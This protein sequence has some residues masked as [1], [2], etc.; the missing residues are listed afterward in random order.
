[1]RHLMLS[2]AALLAMAPFAMAAPHALAPVQHEAVTLS[3]P[4][5]PLSNV[6]L[7]KVAG[8]DLGLSFQVSA[9]LVN[10]GINSSGN[11]LNNLQSLQSEG[12]GVIGAVSPFIGVI[13]NNPGTGQP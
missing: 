10:A 4:A 12:N 2:S 6:Q 1:M 9:N 3:V 5:T 7:A 13:S 8:G 11:S